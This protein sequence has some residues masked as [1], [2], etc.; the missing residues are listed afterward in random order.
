MS[1]CLNMT[2]TVCANRWRDLLNC[3]IRFNSR[4]GTIWVN[5]DGLGDIEMMEQI[6]KRFN[7]HPLVLEDIFNTEQRSKFED[8][9]DYIYMVLKTFDYEHEGGEEKLVPI[10]SVWW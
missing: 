5:L 1:L 6:G 10:R 7:L 4:R 2:R 8:Y 9:G 3:P